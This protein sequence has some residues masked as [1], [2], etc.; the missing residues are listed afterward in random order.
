VDQIIPISFPYDIP[1][2]DLTIQRIGG[3]SGIFL[4]DGSDSDISNV[5]AMILVNNGSMGVE[6]ADISLYCNGSLLQFRATAL[7]A[8]S[9]IMVQEVNATGHVKNG[10]Y[11]ECSASVAT[12]DF[13]EL[14]DDAVSVMET[15]DG[16]L[17]VT[18]L[19]DETIPCVRVFYKFHMDSQDL[20]VG[21]IS[22]VAKLVD[23]EAGQSQ[24][25]MPSHYLPGSSRVVMV[26]IYDT[27]E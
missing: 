26:R 13:F 1:G 23:L 20:Y 5:A 9:T 16:A 19:T 22:Y 3:Y 15:D 12:R 4:E 24:S 21:G 25:I 14:S 2:T 6:L 7:P 10:V 18:N 17:Q 27:A 8:N 11:T